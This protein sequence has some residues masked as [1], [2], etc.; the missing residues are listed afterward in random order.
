[1]HLIIRRLLKLFNTYSV[2]YQGVGVSNNQ[3]YSGASGRNAW[4]VRAGIK[5]KYGKIFT[6]LLLASKIP[7]MQEYALLIFYNNKQDSDNVV[8]G[9]V[10]LFLDSFKMKWAP[11]DSP[12]YCKL[13]AG[14]YDPTLTKG[15][16]EFIIIKLK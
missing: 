7:K 12:K 2:I 8:G 16:M 1:M 3:F 15:T 6:T 9:T 10:K 5:D 4:R 14:I 11:D 13:V